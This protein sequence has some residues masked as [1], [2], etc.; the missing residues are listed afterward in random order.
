MSKV[1]E[2]RD[3]AQ[4]EY[5]ASEIAQMYHD[6]ENE[7]STWVQEKVELRN[8]VFATDTTK[9][10]NN[11]LPWK[12]KTTLPKICQIRDNLHANYMAAM[13]PN[14]N[15]LEW[16]A[17]DQQ[18]SSRAKADAIKAYMSNKLRLWNFMDTVSKL[19]YDYIDYGNVFVDC[20]YVREY[21]ERNGEEVIVRQGPRALRRSPLD[22]VF[23]PTAS[24]FYR[25]FHIIRHVFSKGELRK[26]V[27]QTGDAQMQEALNKIETIRSTLQD[28][29]PSDVNKAIGFKID[30][31]GSYSDYLG[32]NYIEI[33][34]FRGDIHD[35]SG[36]FKEN[37][38]ILIADRTRVLS[39]ESIS[40]WSSKSYLVHGG[41][42][43]RPDNLYAMGPMDN[44]VG[45]QYRIDHL[46]NIKAD[47]FDL[48]AHPPLKIR[49]Q[50]EEFEWEPFAQIF[51][52][53]DG[54]IDTLRVDSA[55]LQADTQIALLEQRMEE[56]AGAPRQSIG[57][58][59]PGE[60]TAFEVNIL[61]QNSSKMF[62]EKVTQF[63]INVL[64][65]LLNNMLE[66]ARQELDGADLIKVIDP[67]IGV[68]EFIQIT[69][70]D[71]RANGILRPVGARHFAARAQAVQNYQGFR[72]I[73]GADPAVMN[74]ISGQ[75][76]AEMFE[77]LLGFSKHD[78]VQPNIRIAEQAES[79]RIIQEISRQLQEEQQTPANDDE[80]AAMEEAR[81]QPMG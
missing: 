49:G 70:D 59:T 80:A 26:Y 51:I 27:K 54:D 18:S 71:I 13:F 45:M 7:R 5:L 64:E 58:R 77:E 2:I 74:H 40:N 72:A 55:A 44:L 65:P 52:G 20:D 69:P 14:D 31:F 61:E 34:E 17:G 15:W 63:E 41:W 60:K 3:I 81:G 4:P 73:F 33:L 1:A 66:L 29:R 35:E 50:V 24:D 25:S 10:S 36:T 53:D 28:Y 12:N 78:L 47:L 42:R 6:Y 22:V 38:R 48:I 56:F 19:L 16:E 57:V 37:R 8:Y 32:S 43:Y 76:E 30:G 75:R 67:D 68:E 21:G 79:Q 62:Q 11:K 9:T 23:N 46:E 39:D